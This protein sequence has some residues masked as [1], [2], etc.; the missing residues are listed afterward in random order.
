VAVLAAPSVELKVVGRN[1]HLN[2]R[3]PPNASQG[4]RE[5]S[6][7]LEKLLPYYT[8][9][10]EY[11]CKTLADKQGVNADDYGVAQQAFDFY[12]LELDMAIEYQGIQ[13]YNGSKLFGKN[14]FARDERKRIF[15]RDLNIDLIEIPYTEE[16]SEERLK[17]SLGI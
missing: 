16:L 15:C 10:Y 11:S 4:H 7:L 3:L 13:H 8:V 9:I 14:S 17:E 5:L 6:I 2:K 12:V 1:K